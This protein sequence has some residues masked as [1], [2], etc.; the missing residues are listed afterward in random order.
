MH[1]VHRLRLDRHAA[2]PVDT[3]DVEQVLDQPAHAARLLADDVHLLD[4]LGGLWPVAQATF[5][6]LGIAA[7]RRQGR[8]EL[9][10]DDRQEVILHALRLMLARHLLLQVGPQCGVLQR[11]SGPFGD[12]LGQASLAV[13]DRCTS[14][15]CGD[16]HATHLAAA[17]DRHSQQRVEP[18]SVDADAHGR[19]V[20]DRLERTGTPAPANLN[21]RELSHTCG[22]LFV[23]TH[24]IRQRHRGLV[25]LDQPERREVAHQAAGAVDDGGHRGIS[26]EVRAEVVRQLRQERFLVLAPPLALLLL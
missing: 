10:A 24:D 3:A 14:G 8:P 26:I 5:K 7:D 4:L 12:R 9:M 20:D 6:E 25:G 22:K 23:A 18:E 21:D 11:G 2:T 17:D 16:Q 13:A 1:E 15:A 19:T